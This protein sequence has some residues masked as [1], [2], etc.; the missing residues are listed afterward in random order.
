MK[1]T[2]LN[3]PKKWTKLGLEPDAQDVATSSVKENILVALELASLE[4][5]LLM[6]I[7][8]CVVLSVVY[9]IFSFP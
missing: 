2:K 1:G 3:S 6:F 4:D 9:L 5:V 8:V 7:Y